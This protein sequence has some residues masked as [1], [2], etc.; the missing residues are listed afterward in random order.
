[1]KKKIALL[2]SFVMLAGCG[3]PK[4]MHAGN[5]YESES[6]VGLETV[7]VL[8][9]EIPTL[10]PGV[11]LNQAGYS[12]ASEKIAV[13]CGENLPTQFHIIDAVTEEKVYTGKL[14]MQCYDADSLE[15]IGYGDF[16]DFA[17]EGEYYVECD[18]LGC[19]YPFTIKASCYEDMMAEGFAIL[20]ERE[21]SLTKEDLTKVCRCLSTLLL[22][23]EL[24]APVYESGQAEGAALVVIEQTRRYAEL[25]LGWQDAET[26]AV[27]SGEAV[28]LTETA[29]LSAALAKFSYTYQ[30]FDSVYA[31]VCLQAADRAWK[32]L[33]KQKAEMETDPCLICV[34]LL[35]QSF[36]GQPASMNIMRQSSS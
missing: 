5:T 20:A 31:T 28:L 21:Q 32:Y 16:T 29:W 13:I 24:Y 14:E 10:L 4:E 25:L 34:F 6:V 30:K 18:I 19:S 26:G 35:Q 3:L 33:E 9:Y 17:T 1:M 11:L 36:T 8:D 23:Y 7:P 15:Y 27:L 22:S 12:P 2:L